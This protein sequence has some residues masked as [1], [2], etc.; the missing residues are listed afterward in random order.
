MLLIRGDHGL[1]PLLAGERPNR[2]DVLPDRDEQILGGRRVTGPADM[3]GHEAGL[4]R[5]ERHRGVAE[6]RLKLALLAGVDR[7][8]EHAD[9]HCLLPARVGWDQ[10]TADRRPRSIASPFAALQTLLCGNLDIAG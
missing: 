8:P 3:L 7:R 5:H 10:P 4:P 1:L 2:L 6:E 9:D